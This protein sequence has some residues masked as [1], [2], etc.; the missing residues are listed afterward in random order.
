MDHSVIDEV[1]CQSGSLGTV[2][3]IYRASIETSV[4]FSVWITISRIIFSFKHP[5]SPSPLKGLHL[6]FVFPPLR[7]GKNS[8]SQYLRFLLCFGKAGRRLDSFMPT[9][10]NIQPPTF[11]DIKHRT[12]DISW[13][14][15]KS[16]RFRKIICKRFGCLKEL[17]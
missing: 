14:I 11:S 5:P 4:S 6:S 17:E 7:E 16:H 2:P 15:R 13:I 8:K 12:S 1:A 10:L 3:T 9:T